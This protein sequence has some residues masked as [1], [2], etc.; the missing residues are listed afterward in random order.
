MKTINYGEKCD[1]RVILLL[2]FFDCLH[3]GHL[4]L[5]KKARELRDVKHSKIALFTFKNDDFSQN[6]TLLC[7]NERI[8]KAE[9]FGVDFIVAATFDESFKNTSYK[10]FFER[11]GATLNIDAI[12]CGFDYKFGK[13]AEGNAEILQNL[14]EKKNIPVYVIPKQKPAVRKYRRQ[15]LNFCLK[16]EKSARQTNF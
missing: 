15:G 12:I 13:N 5:I 8:E 16:T 9:R 3:K 10:D 7:Y 1:E 6:G 11:L 14:C 4:E 2:G